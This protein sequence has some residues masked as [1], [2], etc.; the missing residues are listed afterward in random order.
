M[1]RGVY[2]R[3][4][5]ARKTGYTEMARKGNKIAQSIIAEGEH[6]FLTHGSTH[7]RE[8]V[9]KL[10][11]EYDNLLRA[12]NLLAEDA[13]SGKMPPAIRAAV[14]EIKMQVLLNVK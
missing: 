13:L 6:E 7:S 10:Q 11:T 8:R 9:A 2:A 3:K 5:K 4:K 12:A 1:P 14:A